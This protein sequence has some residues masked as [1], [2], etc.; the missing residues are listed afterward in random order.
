LAYGGLLLGIPW[1]HGDMAP[2]R[3]LVATTPFWVMASFEAYQ[4][5]RYPVLGRLLL[6]LQLA[7]SWLL[8]ALPW[9][10]FSKQN[11]I[12]RLLGIVGIVVHRNLSR[13]F[14]SFNGDPGPNV[15]WALAAACMAVYLWQRQGSGSPRPS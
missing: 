2:A 5:G 3:Y 8:V 13:F 15:A 10:C 9:F 11:G 12:N 14:P 7:W 6:G 4:S 1:W